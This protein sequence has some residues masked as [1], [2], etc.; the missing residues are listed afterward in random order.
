VRRRQDSDGSVAIL[1]VSRPVLLL[2]A[3]LNESYRGFSIAT[4]SRSCTGRDS[5][6]L[7]AAG[8]ALMLNGFFLWRDL[9]FG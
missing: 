9:P 2:S 1:A 4:R 5:F 7:G 6:R 3:L 8:T